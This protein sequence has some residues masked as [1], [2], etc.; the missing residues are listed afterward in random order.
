M[1]DII[2]LAKGKL[3][4]PILM[5][6]ALGRYRAAKDADRQCRE[7][8]EQ[9][10]F[11]DLTL[12]RWLDVDDRDVLT[13]LFSQLPATRFANLG[14][15]IGE[16][17]GEWSGSL[18]YHAAP[19][20]A[21]YRPD[22]AWKCFAEPQSGRH[23]DTDSVL[24]IIRGLP[25]LP[26]EDGRSLLRAIAEQ[27]LESKDDLS[28]EFILG[29]LLSAALE[30]DRDIALE[31]LRFQLSAANKERELS[32]TLGR[33]A[34]GLFGTSVH[35][36]LAS[37]IRVGG[38]LQRFP[39]L[40][41]I[42]REDAPLDQLDRWCR[43]P[44]PLTDL[45]DLAKV[46]LSEQDHALILATVE[47]LKGKKLGRHWGRV[48]DFLIGSI[49]AACERED[50]DVALMGL[51][52]TVNLLAVDLSEVRHFDLLLK[53]LC[54]FSRE[55]VVALL[56]KTLEREKTTYGGVNVAEVMGRLGWE[57][58]VPS[59]TGAMSED[60]GDLLCEAAQKALA[61]IGNEAQRYLIRQWDMLDRSQRIYGLS[62]IVAVGEDAAAAFALDRYDDLMTEYSDYWCRLASAAPDRHLFD[63][64]EKQ[65]AR[66]QRLFDDTFYFLARLLDVDHP[67]LD[68]VRERI[69]RRRAEQQSRMAAFER[70]DWFQDSLDLALRC[71]ECGDVNEYRVRKI[72][73][74]PAEAGGNMQLAQ[75]FVCAS[76]GAWADFEFTG[77]AKLAVTAELV[78]LAAD[79][80]AGLA[81]R[82]NV[83][84]RIEA[85]W[86]G[87]VLPVGEVISRCKAAV[88][89]D[90]S[91]FAH[92][93]RLGY[94]YHQSL[95]RPRLALKY[96]EQALNLE[97]NAVEAVIQRADALVL[98]G[99]DEQ[100]FDLLD[101]A[102][103]SKDHWRFF[104]ADVATPAQLAA[105]FAQLY[106]ELLQR[107]GRTD[108]PVLHASFLGAGKKVGRNDPCPCGSGKK[109]KKCCLAGE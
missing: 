91:S 103:A 52:E 46:F 51:Q 92:W 79:S 48:A 55:E 98:Q 30:L 81:G 32:Q 73:V 78:K 18:A 29:G 38:T 24:G 54:T 107:L 25:S 83:L 16:R 97:Q 42:F 50:L 9:A 99:Q 37:E 105:R 89:Q 7:V 44:P 74:D 3:N 104:L 101:K 96:A 75:E 8:M 4:D 13:R 27:L 20:L 93:V 87:K 70:G 43:Q 63:L 47:T 71:P 67:Q 17:W 6:W 12:R 45:T 26:E 2:D 53:R 84:V 66:Q 88:A 10:W 56:A 59:L 82:S 86:N 108:R 61:R 76:C 14:Q 5:E 60:C 19:V 39:S 85:S 1:T 15:A 28:R 36:Q 77:E 72:A 34:V 33:I 100:A 22:L 90:P 40:A 23:P 57:E 65:L 49:A 94:C 21:R 62:V 95:A 31:I 80:D 58:F 106:N 102:L 109:Y 64:L 68:A 11:D 41:P 35:Q 69:G